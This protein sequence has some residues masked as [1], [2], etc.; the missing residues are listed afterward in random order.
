M[1]SQFM[2][3]DITYLYLRTNACMYVYCFFNQQQSNE[4]KKML[5]VSFGFMYVSLRY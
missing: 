3:E 2:S 1:H 5:N 4:D